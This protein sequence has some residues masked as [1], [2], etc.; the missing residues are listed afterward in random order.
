[1]HRYDILYVM[2]SVSPGPEVEVQFVGQLVMTATDAY[3]SVAVVD[4]VGHSFSI[5]LI[6]SSMRSITISFVQIPL[7]SSDIPIST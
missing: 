6:A 2:V 3:A 4:D 1:M 5:V 7:M